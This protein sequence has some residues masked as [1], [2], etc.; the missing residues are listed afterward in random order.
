M[1]KIIIG[2]SLI[3]LALVL[4]IGCTETKIRPNPK[5]KQ[6]IKPVDTSKFET[7]QQLKKFSSTQELIEYLKKN[8]QQQNYFGMYSRGGIMPALM[9]EGVAMAKSADMS[10]APSAGGA[11]E[12]S[13][14]NIQVEGVDEADFVKNDDKYIYIIAQNKIV[15]VDAYPAEKAK[16][17]SKTDIEGEGYA[18]NLFVNG[19]RLILFT[20]ANEESYIIPEFG[21]RPEMRS[22]QRTH[23]YVYDISDRSEPELVKDYSVS[24]SYDDARMIGDYVYFIAKDY[25][26]YYNDIIDLPVL[27][28]EKTTILR[29]DVY[30]FD[31]PE[32]NFVFHTIASINIKD[33]EEVN[34]KTFLMGYSNT[35]Y[36]SQDNIY[37]SYQRNLPY[38]YYEEDS[39]ERFYKVVVP[40]LPDDAQ[41]KI[42]AIK[43]DNSLNS[44]EKWQKVS[45]ALEDMY[46]S[47]D[48]NDKRVLIEEIDKAISEYEAKIQIERT[49]TIIQKIA[50]DKGRI[51]YVAK[52][53]VS[54]TLLNQFSLDEFEGNLRLATTTNIWTTRGNIQHNNVYVLDEDMKQIG[55]LEE[56]APDERIY[57]TRFIGDRLYMVTFQRIDPLFVIDLSNPERPKILGELKIPGFS[58]YLHP[59][60]ANHIIG[61]GKET[62]S[63][64]W[65]GV[66]IKGLKLALFDVS[67]VEE[68]KQIAVY[69]IGKSGTDSEALNEHKA[70]LF[71]KKKNLLVIPVREIT[72]QKRIDSRYGYYYDKV[73]QGAYVFNIDLENGFKLKGKVSHNEASEDDRYYWGSP[74]AVRRSIFMDDVLYTVSA[75]KIL[76]NSLDDVEE[77]INSIT[78]PFKQDYYPYP[79]VY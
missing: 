59:Y 58:D 20:T 63:N 66:S 36:V 3:V 19:D 39:R 12:F 43:N 31:N 35:L 77:E 54:G 25:V 6:D 76:M 15:I 37:I 61:I 64:E 55:K 2:A 69:E 50:I 18:S 62:G 26:Y 5:D 73:W 68:P 49:K 38:R 10:N 14:T 70:F 78:L 24:G 57:S 51:E 47:M 7:S 45:S 46:N 44:Y 1:K 48:E 34:A 21:Y 29:P 42:N 8:S 27:K 52:G 30:Y 72:G 28:D 32:Q 16:I 40:L 22:S 60:D 23:A 79:V 17:L 33:E 4:L 56:I 9:A 65:G 75:K 53:E 11:A 13:Q 67:D 71:D 41:D 74:Y